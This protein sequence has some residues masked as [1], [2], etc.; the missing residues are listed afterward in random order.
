M[1]SSFKIYFLLTYTK[2]VLKIWIWYWEGNANKLHK[3][4]SF[5]NHS[6]KKS[7]HVN[8]LDSTVFHTSKHM[9]WSVGLIQTWL[10]IVDIAGTHQMSSYAAFISVSNTL[11]RASFSH[12][13]NLQSTSSNYREVPCKCNFTIN[14]L[15]RNI[16]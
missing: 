14:M 6:H 3:F 11:D 15:Y 5:Q 13:F 10:V 16:K 8:S 1:K 9:T 2:A 7:E 12:I 4:L